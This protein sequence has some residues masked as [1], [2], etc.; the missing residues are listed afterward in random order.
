MRVALACPYAWDS[1]GGVQTHVRQLAGRLR[2]HGHRVLVLAPG[3]TPA[4]EPF[5]RIVGRP[6]RVPYQGTVAPLSFSPG[7]VG[8]VRAA[9]RVFRPDILHVHEP[10]TP[11]TSMVAA[12]ASS[13][14][15]MATFHAH[16]ERSLLFDLGAPLVRPVWRRLAV[17][18]AVSEAARRFVARRMGDGIRIIPNGVDVERF[19][20][21][22]PSSDLP[23]GRRLLWVGRL[24]PQKGFPVAVQ[25]FARLAGSIPDLWLVVA[26]DGRDRDAVGRVDL[27]VRERVL[28]LGGVAHDRLPGYYRAADVFVSAAV[29]QESF[30]L[31]LVEAMAAGLPV[32]ATDIPG[33]REVVRDGVDGLLVP[34]RDPIALADAAAR[35]L[36][37]PGAARMYA[38]AGRERAGRYSWD[39]VAREIEEAYAEAA[40]EG[41][42]AR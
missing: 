39:H 2:D 21:A 37:D 13:A 9:L 32:V 23:P 41:P 3:S 18:A 8:R 15:V 1:P 28:M 6:L 4:P 24:D 11:S 14:P 30:G 36:D 27:T 35:V 22:M 12:L 5:V 42:A 16:S 19:A 40:G 25:A 20:E 29:G 26:G 34:P 33:Y 10:L 38:Q 31:V 7:S 17:R